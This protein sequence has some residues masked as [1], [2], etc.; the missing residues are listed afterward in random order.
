MSCIWSSK[1]QLQFPH[2]ILLKRALVIA[3]Q[4][5]IIFLIIKM[6]ESTFISEKGY[7]LVHRPLELLE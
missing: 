4:S 2:Y 3:I 7:S 6:K 1:L 5:I